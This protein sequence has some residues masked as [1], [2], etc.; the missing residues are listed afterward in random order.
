M[1]K[2]LLLSAALLI[3]IVQ[4]ASARKWS[5]GTNAGTWADL[6]T[7]NVEGSVALS[8]NFTLLAGVG[9]NPWMYRNTGGERFQNKRREAELGFRW[10]PWH[11]YSGWWLGCNAQY[12]EYNQGGVISSETEEG[13]A[14][15]MALS[16]GYTLMLHKN[17]NM[18]FGLGLRAG[19]TEY[20]T[21]SCPQCGR[22]TDE[23][24]KWF[25]LPDDMVI[26]FVWVF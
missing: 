1:R 8:R 18:E 11:V 13:N 15:G 9:Y 6:G 14:V 10:W 16:A 2:I 23:G 4:N 7:M 26:S 3:C 5:V 17:F 12:R 24:K 22:V 25:I 19:H 20:V 21:Y